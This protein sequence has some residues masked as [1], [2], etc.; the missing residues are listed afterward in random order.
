MSSPCEMFQSAGSGADLPKAAQLRRRVSAKPRRKLGVLIGGLLTHFT[1]RRSRRGPKP[2]NAAAITPNAKLTIDTTIKIAMFIT[3][4]GTMMLVSA[5]TSV[6]HQYNTR[7]SSCVEILRGVQTFFLIQAWRWLCPS[8]QTSRCR[9]GSEGSEWIGMD[10]KDRKNRK[11]QKDQK[12]QKDRKDR[13]GSEGSEGSEGIT[14]VPPSFRSFR[15]SPIRQTFR[16]PIPLW[17]EVHVEQ[18]PRSGERG[19]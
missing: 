18:L 16:C 19:Y 14:M 11:D 7:T 13:N 9:S 8:T 4:A 15:S 5:P 3:L 17:D 2:K 10:R 1:T 12:D 6:R